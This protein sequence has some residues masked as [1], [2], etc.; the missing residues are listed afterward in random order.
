MRYSL[1]RCLD[2]GSNWLT[3][4]TESRTLPVPAAFF[5]GL[6]FLGVALGAAGAA[7]AADMAIKQLLLKEVSTE[8]KATV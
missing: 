5:L 4:P 3:W 1:N 8:R 7:S 2:R 6:A